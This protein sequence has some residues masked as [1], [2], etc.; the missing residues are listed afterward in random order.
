MG[1]KAQQV[2]NEAGAQSTLSDFVY[3]EKI[4]E[5]KKDPW[6][7]KI[8]NHEKGKLVDL[9]SSKKYDLLARYLINE[10]KMLITTECDYAKSG[11]IRE[12]IIGDK[13]YR[14]DAYKVYS[15]KLEKDLTNNA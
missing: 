4:D 14:S 11:T 2:T 12:I 1:Y 13:K 15:R 7:I 9:L 10:K 3:T 5:T 6:L 8:S